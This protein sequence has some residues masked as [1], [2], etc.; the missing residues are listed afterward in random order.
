M[1]KHVLINK[2]VIIFLHGAIASRVDQP[3]SKQNLNPSSWTP[4]LGT[5]D[6]LTMIIKKLKIKSY[7]PPK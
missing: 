2:Y 1:K 6:K 5:F 4:P 7:G 3:V